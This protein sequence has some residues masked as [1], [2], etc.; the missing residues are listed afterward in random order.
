[1]TSAIL[2]IYLNE[3]DYCDGKPAHEKILEFMR[4][5]N[6]SGATVLHGIEGYGVHSKI[7]TTSILR[8]GTD[9]PIVV[10]AVD[11]EEKIRKIL[12]ELCRMIPKELITL[13]KVEIISGENV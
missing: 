11:S 13:Q 8:L 4:D 12:P 9:L 2:R 1:M 6:I 10:E 5:S 7:H 3:N